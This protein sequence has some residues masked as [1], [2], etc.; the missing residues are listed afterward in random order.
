MKTEV[1][2]TKKQREVEMD[3][4][5]GAAN[6]SDSK[7]GVER[8]SSGLGPSR[9]SENQNTHGCPSQPVTF[10]LLE[11][12]KTKQKKKGGKRGDEQKRDTPSPLSTGGWGVQTRFIHARKAWKLGSLQ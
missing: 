11:Q 4:K 2:A 6:A 9:T 8:T 10:L 5:S 3:N 1:Q 7:A 12:D